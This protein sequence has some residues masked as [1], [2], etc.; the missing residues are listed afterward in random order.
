M[1]I[2]GVQLRNILPVNFH[3]PQTH[4]TAV[5]RLEPPNGFQPWNDFSSLLAAFKQQVQAN[6]ESSITQFHPIDTSV[7]PPADHECN[8]EGPVSERVTL[9]VN[10]VRNYMSKSF[11]IQGNA[12]Q[13]SQCPFK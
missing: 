6:P 5:N 1:G 8:I 11:V 7:P 13:F 2:V 3:R 10:K 12:M 9:P 4:S